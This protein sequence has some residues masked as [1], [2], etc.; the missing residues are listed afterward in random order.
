MKILFISHVWPPAI[1]GGSQIVFHTQKQL[2]KL[3]HQTLV[4]TTNCRSTDDFVIPNSKIINLKSSYIIRLPVVKTKFF[5]YLKK[6]L[7][8]LHLKSYILNLARTGPIF[9]PIA[10]AK[11]LI[12]IN[13]F[14]PDLIVAGP[15]PTTICPYSLILKKLFKSKLLL[16]PCF[17]HQ[18][19]SF[20][21]LVLTNTLRQSD[22]IWCLSDFEKKYL[23]KK[24]KISNNKFFVSPPGIS[25]K[26]LI[27]PTQK[28]ANTINLL[29][30]GNL[31]AHKKIDILLSAFD[32]ICQQSNNFHLTIAGQK[33]LYYPQ[34]MTIYNNL[35]QQVKNRITI[36]PQKY[37]TKKLIKLLNQSHILINPSINE[38]YGIVFAESSSRGVPVIGS[39]IP[40]VKNLIISN[41]IG[42]CFKKDNP[43]SLTK[44]ILKL[45]ANKSLYTKLSKNCLRYSQNL[46]WPDIINKLNEKIA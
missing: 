23:I 10:L 44:T 30:L 33:T 41:H 35:P 42:L 16:I 2:E 5:I 24:F 13:N 8:L 45:S 25:I 21:N 27:K 17:H 14:K 9:K 43:E 4:L 7:T 19:T 36:L 32:K 11:A 15:F 38:S 29:F 31:A 37:D 20:L 26:S 28:P 46:S 6:F 40:T 34:I 18:D 3:G 22:L 12:K 39:N 1:D